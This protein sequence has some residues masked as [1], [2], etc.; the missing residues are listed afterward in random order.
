METVIENVSTLAK[1]KIIDAERELPINQDSEFCLNM[2]F[3]NKRSKFRIL[4]QGCHSQGKSQG[5]KFFFKIMEKSG[6]FVRE[7][8]LF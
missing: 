4:Q 6:N 7:N 3:V 5:K 2:D 8:D 1:N